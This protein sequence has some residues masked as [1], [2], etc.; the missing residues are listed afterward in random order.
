[1]KFSITNYPFTYQ[2]K[3]SHF[4]LDETIFLGLG[5]NIALRY[6]G[7][8]KHRTVDQSLMK[9]GESLAAMFLYLEGW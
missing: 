1:M 4:L 8:F 6:L 9:R 5:L 7:L 3:I 2:G